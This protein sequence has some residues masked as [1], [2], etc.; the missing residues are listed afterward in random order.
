LVTIGVRRRKGPGPELLEI[1]VGD[2]GVGIEAAQLERIFEPFYQVDSSPTRSF[3]GVGL[4]LAL[5]KA[6]AEAH[7]GQVSVVSTPGA[8]S[9]F[10]VVLPLVGARSGGA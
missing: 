3:P 1:E 4:G 9:R 6:H 5:V 10:T 7:G 2:S 8:G